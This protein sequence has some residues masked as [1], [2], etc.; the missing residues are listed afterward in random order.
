[1]RKAAELEPNQPRYA[2]VYAVALHS[3]GRYGEAMTVLKETLRNHPS[4]RE[5]LE[6]LVSFSRLAGDEAAAIRY[7]EQLEILRS[8][9]P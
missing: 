9:K 3:G 5:I 1:M 8:G 2:Y 6:A 7:A 4:N